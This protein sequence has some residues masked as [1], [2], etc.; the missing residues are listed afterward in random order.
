[1]VRHCHLCSL[2]PLNIINENALSNTAIFIPECKI[3]DRA[4]FTGTWCRDGKQGPFFKLKMTFTPKSRGIF[5][6]VQGPIL[7]AILRIGARSFID[8]KKGK[9]G[10]HI[11]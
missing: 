1:M 11:F 2:Q 9:K 10:K 3:K 7:L 5:C 8:S 4:K 6:R